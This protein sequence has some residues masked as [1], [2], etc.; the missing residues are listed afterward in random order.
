VVSHILFLSWYCLSTLGVWTRTT[1]YTQI[2]LSASLGWD[3]SQ[4]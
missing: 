3:F 4:C 1:S 2:Y